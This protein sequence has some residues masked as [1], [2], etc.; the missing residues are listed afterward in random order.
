VA[1]SNGNPVFLFGI[2]TKKI[3]PEGNERGWRGLEAG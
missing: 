3:P 2:L 1:L